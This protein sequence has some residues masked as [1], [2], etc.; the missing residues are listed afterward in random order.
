MQA[1]SIFLKKHTP[2][3]QTLQMRGFPVQTYGK[4][5]SIGKG[6]LAARPIAT[7]NK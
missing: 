3:L 5:Y 2:G 7:A 4:H 6:C 1:G